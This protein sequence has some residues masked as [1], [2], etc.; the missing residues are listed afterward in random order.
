MHFVSEGM[1]LAMMQMTNMKAKQTLFPELFSAE[2]SVC[3]FVAF[4]WFIL[5]CISGHRAIGFLFQNT[6]SSEEASHHLIF[7]KLIALS[8]VLLGTWWTKPIVGCGRIHSTA[9]S[10]VRQSSGGRHFQYKLEI[11]SWW[12]CS[13]HQG[14]V[15]KRKPFTSRVLG[16]CPDQGFCAF[17]CS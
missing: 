17:S 4:V 11:R 15:Q 7:E 13:N 1:F 16:K 8:S 3:A 9:W 6:R 14:K 10:P 5:C 2:S 12:F